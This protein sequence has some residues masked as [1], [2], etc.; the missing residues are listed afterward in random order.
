MAGVQPGP[1]PARTPRRTVLG[2]LLLAASGRKEER[3]RGQEQ[4][5]GRQQERALGQEPG[6]EQ[7][8]E[9]GRGRGRGQGQEQEQGHGHELVGG[10]LA[11]VELVLVVVWW[12]AWPRWL[13]PSS[14]S[15]VSAARLPERSSPVGGAGIPP[16]FGTHCCMRPS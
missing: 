9:L 3:G 4:E 16:S 15:S 2:L 7:E 11:V 13:A 8:R 14:V 1:Y 10:G 5:Q 12:A 6:Q